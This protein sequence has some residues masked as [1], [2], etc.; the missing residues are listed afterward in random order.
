MCVC[1]QQ[2]QGVWAAD[3]TD[4]TCVAVNNKYRLMAFGC[5]RYVSPCPCL[6]NTRMGRRLGCGF[7]AHPRVTEMDCC[8]CGLCVQCEN[9]S[10]CVCRGLSSVCLCNLPSWQECLYFIAPCSPFLQDFVFYLT[11]TTWTHTHT[12]SVTVLHVIIVQTV[13]CRQ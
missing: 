5:A 3:V 7:C 2:L 6:Y 11:E 9:L 12:N 10:V 8:P 13:I 1:S 4:G